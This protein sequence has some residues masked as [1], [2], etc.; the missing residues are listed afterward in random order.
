VYPTTYFDY[1]NHSLFPTEMPFTYFR[2]GESYVQAGDSRYAFP[3][4]YRKIA[5]KLLNAETL[6]GGFYGNKYMPISPI[7]QNPKFFLASPP[8]PTI[9]NALPTD[10]SPYRYFV[11]DDTS[12][13]ITAIYEKA[14]TANKIVIK[15]NTLMSVPT[16]NIS[17]NGSIITV[18][19]SQSIVP[20]NNTDGKNT[21]LLTLYWTGSAWTK[22]K[23][24]T[25]PQFS[26]TGS[27][28]LS[29]TFSKITVTQ[30]GKTVN[31]EFLSYTA[32]SVT[33]DLN[34]MQLIEVSPR[35][36]IDLTDFVENL[37]INKSLDSS[38]TA[39]PISSL[40]TNDAQITLS[41]IPA[42]N[43]S[44]L[45]PIF[46][47]QSDQSSTILAN[48]LRKNI[49]FYVNFNL[50]SYSTA[51]GTTSPNTYIPGGV[52]YSDSW[53]ENDIQNVSIQLFDVARYLQ[54]TPVP[55]Y[56]ANLKT[57]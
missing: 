39:L 55:D 45:V 20:L 57:V 35:L 33:S 56:V 29:T 2:P 16:V 26:T 43:G 41:G 50:S 19:G 27:L 14:I 40:N 36:E 49:K 54:S 15:F 31:S 22:T 38:N 21:G 25:M 4:A 9:K 32:D 48:M 46:S 53:N 17:I 52:F 10:I 1:Q 24:S 37:S 44:T 13:S 47:S 34:R 3:A 42:M 7:I 28:S 51:S 5:S 30:T 11:S 23:W 8:V 12:K 6:S 18:D